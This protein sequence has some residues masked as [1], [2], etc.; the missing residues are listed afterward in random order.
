MRME[1][2]NQ[3][4]QNQQSNGG[5]KIRNQAA[6][7]FITFAVVERPFK[8]LRRPATAKY[9]KYVCLHCFGQKDNTVVLYRNVF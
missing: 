1:T 7:H 3:E 2:Y 9:Y 6:I 8:D 5:Y 4:E